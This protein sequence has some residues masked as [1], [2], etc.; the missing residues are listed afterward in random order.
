MSVRYEKPTVSEDASWKGKDSKKITHPAYGMI[1]LS[2][3]T[4]NPPMHLFGSNIKHSNFICLSI[5]TAERST[6]G[7][8]EFRFA[9]KNLIEVWISGTQLGDM[10]S[11]MNVG[12]GVPCTIR[13]RETD[14]DIP[15]IADEDT[16]VSD[17]RK[18]LQ[19][20]INE[21]TR[22]AND[23]CKQSKEL[24]KQPTVKKSDLKELDNKLDRILVELNSNLGYVAECFDEKV[25]K[26]VTHA[27]GE[28][29]AF[30]SNVI[31]SAGIKAISEGM[32][33][34]ELPFKLISINGEE[35]N[36]EE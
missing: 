30:V 36:E 19:N 14:Y 27:K 6:D 2:R 17:S 23:L 7:N 12:E 26:T 25:E 13:Y 20:R 15:L 1:G 3:C 33:S 32:V 11:S 24:L 8:H 16:I 4:T 28:V 5:K 31:A 10:L 34:T 22:V 18:A 9:K 35:K 29:D 21:L